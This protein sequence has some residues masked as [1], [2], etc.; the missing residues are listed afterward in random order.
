MKKHIPDGAKIFR[1]GFP[2]GELEKND[3]VY[4]K[5]FIA[6]TC[7]SEF[8]HLLQIIPFWVFGL[9]APP[10]VIWVMLIYA[11]ILNVP[12]IIAQRYNRPRIK[13][14]LKLKQLRNKIL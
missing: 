1:K 9:F 10:I 12:C 3:E 7:R 4:L 2:K 13:K 6:E 14:L 11:L 5:M 8:T